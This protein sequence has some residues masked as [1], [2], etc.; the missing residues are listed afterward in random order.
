MFFQDNLLN[1]ESENL[2]DL[3]SLRDSPV[4]GFDGSLCVKK[5]VLQFTTKIVVT[6]FVAFITFMVAIYIKWRH[7]VEIYGLTWKINRN[8]LDLCQSEYNR[9]SSRVSMHI[10]ISKNKLSTE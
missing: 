2:I 5:K 1:L 3:H 4:C 9:D 6:F 7:E 8:D 10:S